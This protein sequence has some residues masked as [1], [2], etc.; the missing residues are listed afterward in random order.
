LR[1]VPV[2]RQT[3][4]SCSQSS[5]VTSIR[6]PTKPVAVPGGTDTRGVLQTDVNGVGPGLERRWSGQLALPEK[7]LHCVLRVERTAAG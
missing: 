5:P 1:T 2:T 3:D 4:P 6:A 7:G